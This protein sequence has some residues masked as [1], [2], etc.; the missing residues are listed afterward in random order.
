MYHSL[1]NSRSWSLA[2][3]TSMSAIG[4]MWNARSQEAYCN[5]TLNCNVNWMSCLHSINMIN[6]S[7]LVYISDL[8]LLFKVSSNHLT[9]SQ[10]LLI[11]PGIFPLVRHG[12][13]VH[14]EQVHPLKV[15]ASLSFSWWLGLV[16]V[17]LQPL[18]NDVIIELFT[19]QKS[20]VSL[21]G[22]PSLL[23]VLHRDFLHENG[24]NY[25]HAK[26]VPKSQKCQEKNDTSSVT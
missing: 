26:L 1:R 23:L 10:I 17:S 5:V 6:F 8:Y 2:N 4:I 14:I 15:S 9:Y 19:P 13:D 21:S 7:R 12:D 18:L 20:G 16:A 3:W 11:Y 24:G 25:N 22:H